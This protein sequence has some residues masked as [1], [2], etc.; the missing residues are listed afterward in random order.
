[1]GTSLAGGKVSGG[2]RVVG[3][4]REEE[5]EV[6]D[7]SSGLDGD[8]YVATTEQNPFGQLD[9]GEEFGDNVVVEGK[10]KEGI[11]GLVREMYD[12][13]SRRGW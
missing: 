6:I 9:M 1:M 11:S 13:S 5:N 8:N 7:E 3:L 4:V 2:R 10:R 12:G